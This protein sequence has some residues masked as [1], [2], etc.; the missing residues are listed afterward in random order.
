MLEEKYGVKDNQVTRREAD[1]WIVQPA[2]KSFR[3]SWL[4][5]LVV[6]PA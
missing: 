5:R 3:L 2:K 1:N 6:A 4:C